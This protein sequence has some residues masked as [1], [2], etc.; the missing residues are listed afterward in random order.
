M[1]RKL[2]DEELIQ[3][4]EFRF[5]ENKK[6]IAEQNLLM[7]QLQHLNRKL[8]QSETMKSNFLSNIRNEI[9]NPFTAILGLSRSIIKSKD[10]D[11]EKIKSMASLI[12]L[13][14][15]G[16]DFQ[17]RNIFA[18]AELEAG[19]ANPQ[20][21]TTDIINL[22][23]NIVESF[24]ETANKKNIVIDFT[25]NKSEIKFNTDSLKFQLIISNLISN[26]LEFSNSDSRI[27]VYADSKEEG[28]LI[29]V[30]DYGIGINK[31]DVS[32]IFDR[33][34]QLDSGMTKNHK[35]HGLGLAVSQALA[36]SLTGHIAVS[37]TAQGCSFI[38]SLSPID[39]LQNGNYSDDGNDTFFLTEEK[40]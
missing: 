13:E 17:L 24:N 9:N 28:L 35:G 38:L 25:S 3:E 27:E 10:V 11:H 22:I 7:A 31:E 37:S 16:L 36:E 32:K 14:A 34:T 19:E 21:I 1:N 20:I 12:H 15:F 6:S 29:T 8:E 26:A 30:K 18:A 23:K 39:Q 33:F 40:F 2:T 5:L 4:L